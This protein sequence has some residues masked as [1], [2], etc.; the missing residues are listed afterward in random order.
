LKITLLIALEL[1]IQKFPL[2]LIQINA[3]IIKK[4]SEP[5]RDIPGWYS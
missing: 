2:D 1:K 4:I 5:K 3:K